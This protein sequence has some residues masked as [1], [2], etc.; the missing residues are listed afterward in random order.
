MKHKEDKQLLK[1]LLTGVDWAVPAKSVENL[2]N[3]IIQNIDVKYKCDQGD[4]EINPSTLY[5]ESVKINKII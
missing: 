5:V 3:E 1:Y 2:Q 4:I